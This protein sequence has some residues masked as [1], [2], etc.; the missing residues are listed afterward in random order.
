MG[1]ERIAENEPTSDLFALL[2]GQFRAVGIEKD[3]D[4][5]ILIE[6]DG[7]VLIDFLAQRLL[8]LRGVDGHL[9]GRA[10]RFGDAGHARRR[11]F[12][13]RIL[14]FLSCLLLQQAKIIFTVIFERVFRACVRLAEHLDHALTA[15]ADGDL[16]HMADA[17]LA[18]HC[19]AHHDDRRHKE[20]HKT[21]RH[22]SSDETVACRGAFFPAALVV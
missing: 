6:C 12:L 20:Q 10:E 22:Q 13:L 16:L 3:A 21:E 2:L 7:Y 14:I 9:G 19:N 18:G 17:E 1:I 4:N 5:A 8:R 15:V 11:Q